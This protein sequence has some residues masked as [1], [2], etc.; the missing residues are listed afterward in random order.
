VGNL[1]EVSEK[2]ASGQGTLGKLINDD[3]LY[4]SV[5]STMKKADRAFDGLGDSGP[6]TAVGVVAGKLF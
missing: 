1:R 6:I 2:L 5:Q 4:L 3:S